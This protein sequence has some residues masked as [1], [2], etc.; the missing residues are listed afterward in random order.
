MT[1]IGVTLTELLCMLG[2]ISCFCCRLL[3]FFQNQLLKKNLSGTLSECQAV[4][5]QTVRKGYQQIIVFKG[6]YLHDVTNQLIWN[7]DA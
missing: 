7:G 6:N 4:W 2:N 5:Y 1:C 3:L